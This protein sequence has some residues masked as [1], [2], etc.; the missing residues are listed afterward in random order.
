MIQELKEFF[1]NGQYY[2]L[3]FKILELQS[4]NK[5]KIITNESIDILYLK[6]DSLI[7]LNFYNE[8]LFESTNLLI[9]NQLDPISKLKLLVIQ[10][11]ALINQGY[12]SQA[13]KTIQTGDFELKCL[14]S[15]LSTDDEKVIGLYYHVKGT[16]YYYRGNLNKSIDF[17]KKALTIREN[18]QQTREISD[19]INN[20][21][22]VYQSLGEFELAT[23]CYLE[24]IS[25]DQ[26]LNFEKGISYSLNNLGFISLQTGDLD[27][28]FNFFSESYALVKKICNLEEPRENNNTTN[29]KFLDSIMI[30]FEDYQFI[31]ELFSNLANTFHRRDD[32]TETLD[33]YAKALYIYQKINNSVLLSDLYVQLISL[34]LEN[35]KYELSKYYFD[36]LNKLN[37]SE[38]K[39]IKIRTKFAKALLLNEQ[40]RFKGKYK[41]QKLFYKIINDVTIDWNISIKTMTILSESLFEEFMIFEDTVIITEAKEIINKMHTIAKDKKSFSL[42]TE[43]YIL[44]MKISVIEGDLDKAMKYLDQAYITSSEKKLGFLNNKVTLERKKLAENYQYWKDFLKTSSIKERFEKIEMLDYMNKIKNIITPFK[45]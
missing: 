9:Q 24:C 45:E 34:H 18:Y 16:F 35:D 6:L 37:S 40:N 28:A 22:Q 32:I 21:G 29:S 3:Y 1:D 41:A 36:L 4:Q 11:R 19:T 2:T 20:L 33:Y 43:T 42:L 15:Q 8:A 44:K 27:E 5:L 31:G 13:L 38:S 17:L 10:I 14:N 12:F 30:H 39:I 23:K 26:S 7:K 25:L